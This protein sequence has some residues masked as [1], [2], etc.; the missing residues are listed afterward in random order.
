MLKFK[1]NDK[2]DFTSTN[3]TE[4]DVSAL[5]DTEFHVI[6]DNKT[7]HVEIQDQNLNDHTLTLKVN[8]QEY[9]VKAQTELDQLLEKMG[10]DTASSSKINELKAP[11]PGAVISIEV[12]PGQS[13][14]KG[15]ALLILE[16]MKMENVLKSPTDG[17]VKEIKTEQGLNVDKND[18]LVVFE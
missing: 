3:D 12:T 14:A 5:S 10:I 8:G 6:K 1:V 11:M 18:V 16:A 17:I 9:F 13:V 4:L 7:F 15:D 2:Y